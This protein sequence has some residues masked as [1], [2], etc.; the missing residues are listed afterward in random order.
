MK[1][2]AQ[3]KLKSIMLMFV[4]LMSLSLVAQNI[5]VKGTVT[6]AT[7]NDA[8]IGATIIVEG[9]ATQ[10][11]VTDIDGNYT[12]AN[13]PS[14]ATLVVSYVGYASKRVPVNGQTVINIVLSEDTELL[15]EV[16]VIGY[17]TQVRSQMTTSVSKLNTKVLESAS[18]SNAATA[19]QGTIPGLKVTL[20][21]GQPGSTPTMQLR[22]GTGFDGS[23]TPLILID[24]VPGSFYALNADDIESMEV[25]KDAASTAIYGARAANGVVIV[26]T[27][28]GKRGKTNINFRAKYT[29]NKESNGLPWSG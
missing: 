29:T 19:L 24:G 13:V 3:Q 27:K 8:V 10:G 17:S 6:D 5:T 16:V 21:T 4:W 11:T 20:N 2:N 25:L 14:D 12:L 1:K 28:K 23:G 26:T 18:R 22:G 9:D 7:F 15:D